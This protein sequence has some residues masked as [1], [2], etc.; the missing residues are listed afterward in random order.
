[1]SQNVITYVSKYPGLKVFIRASFTISQN[2]LNSF[3][4]NGSR[5]SCVL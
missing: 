4:R 2:S 1:M 3:V 5:E